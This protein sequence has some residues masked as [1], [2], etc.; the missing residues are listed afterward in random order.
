MILHWHVFLF[1]LL[2]PA[3][4]TSFESSYSENFYY[5]IYVTRNAVTYPIYR[6]PLAIAYRLDVILNITLSYHG[7]T[8]S[9]GA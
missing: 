4:Q 8:E 7:L 5:I 1:V 6:G 9:Y 3:S 2:A